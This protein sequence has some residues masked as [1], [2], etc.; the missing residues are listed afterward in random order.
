MITVDQVSNA[1]RAVTEQRK[2]GAAEA[3]RLDQA[4]EQMW[5]N[6]PKNYQWLKR[7]WEYV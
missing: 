7:E 3:R 6:L 1:A 5:S 4:V 2:L